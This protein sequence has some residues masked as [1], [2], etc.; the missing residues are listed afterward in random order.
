MHPNRGMHPQPRYVPRPRN[1]PANFRC[2][3]PDSNQLSH[4]SQVHAY[5]FNKE[6]SLVEEALIELALELE[7]P[8]WVKV[9]PSRPRDVG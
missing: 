2:I 5:Y 8:H 7:R 6:I 4:T 9:P 1:K 3:G